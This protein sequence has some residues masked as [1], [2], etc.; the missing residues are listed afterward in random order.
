MPLGLGLGLGIGKG[1]IYPPASS[2]PTVAAIPP[3]AL[4][5]DSDGVVKVKVADE[6]LTMDEFA[7]LLVNNGAPITQNGQAVIVDDINQII[8]GVMA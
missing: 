2:W 8:Y 5:L 1:N 3:G 7:I 4:V 6:L